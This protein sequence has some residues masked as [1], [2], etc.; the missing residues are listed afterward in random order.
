MSKKKLA[1]WLDN[2]GRVVEKVEED[3]W[4]K[5]VKVILRL[6]REVTALPV[7]TDCVNNKM[8]EYDW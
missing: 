4:G 7:G 2:E 5:E 6:P 3:W 1:L 8:L